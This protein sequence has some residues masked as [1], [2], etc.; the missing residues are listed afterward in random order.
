[1]ENEN[2]YRTKNDY[3]IDSIHDARDALGELENS[4]D[5]LDNAEYAADEAG[6][7]VSRANFR[8]AIRNTREAIKLITD[9]IASL[10]L[11]EEQ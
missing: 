5:Y 10:K 11:E 9:G 4:L 7:Y 6:D 8:D 2:Y 3:V 1:M